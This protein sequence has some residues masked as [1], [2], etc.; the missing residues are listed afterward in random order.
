MPVQKIRREKG[1]AGKNFMQSEQL[2]FL[3]SSTWRNCYR[4]PG[5]FLDFPPECVNRRC[6]TEAEASFIVPASAVR[7][8]LHENCTWVQRK[9]K[10]TDDAR[11]ELL[12]FVQ[13]VFLFPLLTDIMF[14]NE[15]LNLLS[16]PLGVT[17]GVARQQGGHGQERAPQQG[18]EGE[19]RQGQGKDGHSAHFQVPSKPNFRKFWHFEQDMTL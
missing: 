7:L 10:F 17:P 2:F 16:L 11:R 15:I 18:G 8:M 5:V 19:A 13:P 3:A 14:H 9:G 1:R 6:R 4:I 12:V